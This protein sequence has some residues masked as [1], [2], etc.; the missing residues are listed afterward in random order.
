MYIVKNCVHRS[1]PNNSTWSIV[2]DDKVFVE[3]TLL[4]NGDS[5]A[6]GSSLAPSDLS[7]VTCGHRKTGK[8]NNK[9]IPRN[10]AFY[11]IFVIH[12]LR[13]SIFFVVKIL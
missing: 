10:K 11:I 7:E 12:F 5:T 6:D 1:K 8:Q 4:V 3:L 9:L 13:Q 2:T